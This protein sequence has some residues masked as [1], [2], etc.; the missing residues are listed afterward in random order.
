L[1]E[2]GLAKHA[3]RSAGMNGSHR[4]QRQLSDPLVSTGEPKGEKDETGQASPKR[5]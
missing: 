2:T 5:A 1:D 4:S 3:G